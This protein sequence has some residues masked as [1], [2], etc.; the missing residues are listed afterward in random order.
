MFT[1][2]D[3]E[4]FIYTTYSNDEDWGLVYC[5]SGWWLSHPSETYQ[6]NGIILPQLNGKSSNSMVPNHQ[7]VCDCPNPN[8][9]SIIV[10]LGFA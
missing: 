7:P 3:W 8:H 6:S 2:H 10:Y 5:L 9:H 4:W 1:T